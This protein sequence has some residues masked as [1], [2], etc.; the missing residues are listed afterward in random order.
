MFSV[1]LCA[2]FQEAPKTSHLEAVKRIFRYI[3]GPTHLRLWHPKGTGVETIVYSDSD[4]AG[5]YVDRKSTSEPKNVNEALGDESWIVA[6]QEELN[7]FIANDIWELVP[8]PKNMTIIGTKWVFRNKLDENGIVSRN[9]ARVLF[10]EDDSEITKDGKVIGNGIR[11]NGLYVMKL[12]NNNAG[13]EEAIER[14]IKLDND[15]LEDES[16]EVDEVVNIKESKSHPLEQSHR[17]TYQTTSSSPSESPTPTHVAP[18]PK[19]RFF[20]PM[21]LEPQELPSQQT[22]THNLHVSIVNNWP[23]GPSNPSPPPRFSHPP[24]GFKHPPPPQP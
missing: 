14:K 8:Q 13:E 16:I 23:P 11:E 12:V 5:D 4:H 9:K 18:P 17:S 3:K 21:K 10:T 22:P 1:C 15:N 19:L 2:R 7:Q 6:M 20:I 24:S